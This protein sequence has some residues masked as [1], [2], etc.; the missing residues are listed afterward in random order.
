MDSIKV[1]R[2]DLFKII[3]RTMYFA[4][5][6]PMDLKHQLPKFFSKLGSVLELIFEL[7]LYF[8]SIH[9]VILYICTIYL[10]FDTG[11]LEFLVNCLMQTV[12]YLW[13]IAMKLYFRR[14]RPKT[15]KSLIDL[16][17]FRYKIRS[18]IGFSYV[19]MDDCL[20][21][22]N[23]WIKFYVY[24]CFLC[25]ILWAMLPITNNDRSLPLTCWYPFDYKKP[26]IYE[27]VY[28]LQFVGQIQV[29]ASFCGSSG[30]HMVLSILISGQYDI[31]FCSLKNIVATVALK[32]GESKENLR[33]LYKKQYD[34]FSEI[35]EF[36]CSKEIFMDIDDLL[37]YTKNEE[38]AQDFRLHFRNAFK[39][40]IDHHRFIWKCLKK[41]ENFY[42]PIWFF[43]TGQVIFLMCL[44]AFVSVKSTTANSS[45]MK[46][47]TLGQYLLMVAL[48]LLVICY[49]GEIICFNSQRCGEAVLRSPW[50][51]HLCDMKCDFLI[52]LLNTQR[53]FILTAGSIFPL[54]IERFKGSCIFWELPK[55]VIVTYVAMKGDAILCFFAT[56]ICKRID[57]CDKEMC[58]YQ[59]VHIAC[60]KTRS[61]SKK[62]E[63]KPKLENM[64]PYIKM[65]LR[66]HN[67]YR[68]LVAAGKV[69]C[70][71]PAVRMPILKWDWGLALT[72]EYNVRTCVF[73]HD[74]CRSTKN[75]PMA[76]Q[77]IYMAK[78]GRL[79]VTVAG[80][81]KEAIFLWFEEQYDADHEIIESYQ[82]TSP[83]T[84]HFTLLVNDRHTR[85]G[86]AF[87][88]DFLPPDKRFVI[89]TCNYSS[90][91]IRGIP[92]YKAG[93]AAS[94]CKKHHSKFKALCDD[95]VDSNDLTWY[96]D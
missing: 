39:D 46:I 94:K 61:F 18:A 38:P 85:V 53:P 4:C 29:A 96:S 15:L 48:E 16:I 58:P 22:T 20:V 72:A 68:N 95:E 42:A 77:N 75:F 30:F 84:G 49:F 43:K 52:F 57:Y 45:F 28:I 25:A 69:K 79:N 83:Q 23:K 47:L 32:Q 5:M 9:I 65:I 66:E 6:H 50:Y 14:L 37:H 56:V 91:N 62:C 17:S 35:N 24:N 71:Y 7:F 26:V 93:P 55:H 34:G 8:V 82:K 1:K 60:N 59:G 89:F 51:T 36:Y 54:N 86:C 40:C 81:I 3:R 63:G 10:N 41:M 70:F 74:Q 67:Y 64:K 33:K 73:A 2:Q 80:F 13:T 90:T 87:L 44:V 88:N 92:S 78:T 31:L 21:M 12:I 76:G 19:T 27:I 11:D